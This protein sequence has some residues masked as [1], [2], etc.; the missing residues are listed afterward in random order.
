MTFQVSSSAFEAGQ[1]GHIVKEAEL[2]G[3]YER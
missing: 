2:V 1:P 3:T